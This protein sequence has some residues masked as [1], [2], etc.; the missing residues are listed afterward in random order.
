MPEATANPKADRSTPAATTERKQFEHRL[1]IN[2]EEIDPNRLDDLEVCNLALSR[3]IGCN[4]PGEELLSDLLL[5]YRRHGRL[6]PEMVNICVATFRQN[7]DSIME[8]ARS[9]VAQYPEFC[10]LAPNPDRTHEPAEETL[11]NANGWVE[12]TPSGEIAYLT[13]FGGVGETPQEIRLTRDE[14]LRLKGQLANLRGLV[15]K[16]RQKAKEAQPHTLL[17]PPR[18]EFRQII[19]L[20]AAHLALDRYMGCNSPAEEFIYNTLW[21]YAISGGFTPQRVEQNL[22]TFC[23]SYDDMAEDVRKFL[24][25]NPEF[26]KQTN[27]AA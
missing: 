4:T 9:F 8:D 15:D 16:A 24:V 20:E 10:G 11:P 1:P 18:P 23:E 5:Y 27:E 2:L 12:A 7:F 21:D 17:L 25:G 19:E 6:T 14:F 3:G 13:M 22:K 26:A